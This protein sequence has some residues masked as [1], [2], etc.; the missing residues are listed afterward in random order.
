M[1]GQRRCALCGKRIS[2]FLEMDLSDS[3]E[4]RKL[5]YQTKG[6]PETLNRNEYSCPECYGSG[7]VW[8]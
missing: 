3:I 6:K 1:F 2:R 4:A 8:G 5:G 7:I